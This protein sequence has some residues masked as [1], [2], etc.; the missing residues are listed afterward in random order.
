M[1]VRR[2]RPMAATLSVT[3]RDQ[4]VGRMR[5]NVMTAPVR[6]AVMVRLSVKMNATRASADQ[7]SVMTMSFPAT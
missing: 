3:A 6:R 1:A 2:I 7:S 5:S 4:T